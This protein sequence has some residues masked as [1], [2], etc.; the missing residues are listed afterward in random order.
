MDRTDCMMC[1]IHGGIV[2]CGYYDFMYNKCEDIKIGDCPDGLDDDEIEDEDE[3]T[4]KEYINP[5]YP[6][7]DEESDEQT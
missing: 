5:Y 6:L 3:D 4:E 2:Y 1:Q 7:P